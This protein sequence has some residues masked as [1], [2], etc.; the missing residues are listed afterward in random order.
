[1]APASGWRGR[2][3]QPYLWFG[4]DYQTVEPDCV[5]LREKKKRESREDAGGSGDQQAR[6]C[7]KP[8]TTH[9]PPQGGPRV[10]EGG[11]H[12][13]KGRDQT[14]DEDIQRGRNTHCPALQRGAAA[15]PRPSPAETDC[16]VPLTRGIRAPRQ[17]TPP[18][19]APH[20]PRSQP[21]TI[22][23]IRPDRK[24]AESA[25]S[26]GSRLRRGAAPPSNPRARWVTQGRQRPLP[27]NPRSKKIF[28]TV[29]RHRRCR[30]AFSAPAA[31]FVTGRS[32]DRRDRRPPPGA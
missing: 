1:M 17:A 6:H 4:G 2:R 19:S 8:S 25:K 20:E 11:I 23:Q 12:S 31:W 5:P 22:V 21:I 32:V 30:P 13:K 27:Y 18:T 7:H 24:A 14:L 9:T 15:R 28:L 26:Y 10:R 29:S 16:A 3:R